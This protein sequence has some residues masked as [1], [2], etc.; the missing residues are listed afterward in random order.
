M[1]GEIGQRVSQN[2]LVIGLCGQS[3]KVLV[4]QIFLQ[5][6]GR[7]GVLRSQVSLVVQRQ[8]AL[9][10]SG[11]LGSCCCGGAPAREGAMVSKVGQA[12]GGEGSSWSLEGKGWSTLGC[13]TTLGD[14]INNKKIREMEVG[15]SL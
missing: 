14:N 5:Q 4:N 15:Q 11:F 2:I 12:R 9:L 1:G 6:Y 8:A 7:E 13:L 3:G 10:H